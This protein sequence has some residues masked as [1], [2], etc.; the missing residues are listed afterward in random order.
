MVS[1]KKI[2]PKPIIDALDHIDDHVNAITEKSE[3]LL[4]DFLTSLDF[5]KQY[6]NNKSTFESYRREI[7]RLLQW[8]WLI[9]KKSILELKR[10]DMGEHKNLWG[11]LAFH[12]ALY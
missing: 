5:L 11:H 7:E 12:H 9:E 2:T 6:K 4:N 8:S 1:V 10:Q 3:Y